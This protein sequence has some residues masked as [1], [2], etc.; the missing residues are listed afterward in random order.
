MNL[1][2]AIK[3]IHSPACI[4]SFSYTITTCN[5]I[6]YPSFWVS[7]SS[8]LPSPSYVSFTSSFIS[9]PPGASKST[10]FSGL[11]AGG[12]GKERNLTCNQRHIVVL[13]GRERR[14]GEGEEGGR[15]RGDK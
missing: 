3:L 1:Q 6:G 4:I 7:L 11:C 14:V 8:S 12:S 5:G 13:R 9:S 2:E 15:G 10:S